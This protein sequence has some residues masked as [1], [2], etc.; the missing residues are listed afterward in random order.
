MHI[1]M[2][3][4]PSTCA[5]SRNNGEFDGAGG[6]ISCGRG[7]RNYKW[8]NFLCVTKPCS[9][10]VESANFDDME[11]DIQ[12]LPNA[13]FY[14]AVYPGFI[15]A[16][17]L[18]VG[19]TCVLSILGGLAIIIHYALTKST[20]IE[21]LH[22]LVCVSIADI[23]VAWGHLWGISTDLERF[24]DVYNPGNTTAVRADQQCPVQAVLAIYGTITSFLWTVLLA[25]LVLVTI[26]CERKTA[27]KALGRLAFT[28]YHL[29]FWVSPLI[30]ICI[31]A[32]LKLLGYDKVDVGEYHFVNL[33]I[34]NCLKR[35]Y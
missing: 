15:L 9:L 17:K 32:R 19:T 3:W 10:N 1:T 7:M 8:P 4:M 28:I 16:L 18:C 34:G 29:I 30:G 27:E 21:L 6:K 20:D 11:F 13:T 2:T 24:L 26:K 5:F 31:L 14:P 12:P 33:L 22:V 23:L 35:K 25:V